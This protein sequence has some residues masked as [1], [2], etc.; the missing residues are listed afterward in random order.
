[1][2]QNLLFAYITL[3]LFMFI[4]GKIY[5]VMEA[6]AIRAEAAAFEKRVNEFMAKGDRFT[7]ADGR[8]LSARINDLQRQLNECQ[9][10]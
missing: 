9:Q 2:R 8:E 7:G 4:G 10:K 3:V 1:M 5:T 6:E